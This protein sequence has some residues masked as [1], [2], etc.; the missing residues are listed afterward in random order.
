MAG[1]FEIEIENQNHSPEGDP[2]EDMEDD[3]MYQD[4]TDVGFSF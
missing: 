1:V 4:V 3:G 2:F